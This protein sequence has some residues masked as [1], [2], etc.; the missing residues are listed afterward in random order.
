METSVEIKD[1]NIAVTRDG[2]WNWFVDQPRKK[3]IIYLFEITDEVIFLDVI[4]D[5]NYME[6]KH[7]FHYTDKKYCTLIYERTDGVMEVTEH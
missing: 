2:S 1:N 4:R 6:Y 7:L 5:I 3:D